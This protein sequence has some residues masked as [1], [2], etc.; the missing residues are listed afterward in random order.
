M[1]EVDRRL[2]LTLDIKASDWC[3][4]DALCVFTGSRGVR[5]TSCPPQRGPAEQRAGPAAPPA[6]QPSLV[7]QRAHQNTPAHAGPLQP[8]TAALQRLRNRHQNCA[9]QRHPHLPGVCEGVSV[10]RFLSNLHTYTDFG[11]GFG[12]KI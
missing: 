11:T 10:L 2:S 4:A 5:R 6:G 1:L 12:E 7:R 3:S 8:G 9:G